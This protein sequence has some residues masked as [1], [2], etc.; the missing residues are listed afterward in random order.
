MPGLFGIYELGRRSL[1]SYQAA[2]NTVGNNVANA[3]SAGYH[4]QRVEL[5]ATPDLRE[6]SGRIGT[7]VWVKSV[8]RIQDH[9]IQAAI[10][11]ETP[12]LGRFEPDD[13]PDL[14]SRESIAR[15]KARLHQLFKDEE[16][17]AAREG[18]LGVSGREGHQ[19]LGTV[20][21]GKTSGDR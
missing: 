16:L 4:R 19:D 17:A 14:D 20:G 13:L 10:I 9:F 6:F 3:G 1:L 12:L 11:R 21:G 5:E 15:L 7:G 8:R 18:G 2:I